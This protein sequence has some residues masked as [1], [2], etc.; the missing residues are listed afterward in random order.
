MSFDAEFQRVV[1]IEGGYSD[2]PIDSGGRTK[3]GVT[4]SVAR[5]YGYTGEMRDLS[6]GTARAIYRERYWDVLK[7]DEVELLAPRVAAELFDT[8]VNCGPGVAGT[9]LQRALN[10]FNRGGSLYPEVVVDG[11]VGRMTLAALSA[12]MRVYSRY[13]ADAEVVMV[14]ALNAQQ[15]AFYLDLATKR[16]KDEEF[17]FGWFRNRVS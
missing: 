6:F 11:L 2:N 3:Y 16:P 12:Y 8:S 10:I 9:F 14:R 15:G 1:M 5:A 7:L 13:S 4:E 17:V